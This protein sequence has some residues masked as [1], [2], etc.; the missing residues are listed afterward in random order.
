MSNIYDNSKDKTI[1]EIVK[2]RVRNVNN[3]EVKI[4]VGYFFLSGYNLVKEDFPEKVVSEDRAGK[5]PFLKIVMGNETSGKT[6]SEIAKGYSLRKEI[7]GRLASDLEVMPVG[8]DQVKAIRDL[9]ELI[10]K[11]V[12][13]IKLFEQARLHAKLYLNIDN[14]E[15]KHDPIGKAIVGSSNFTY[16]GMTQNRELNVNITDKGD[17][18]ELNVW[19]DTLWDEADDFNE[20]L[21]KIIGAS[22]IG[23]KIKETES[24]RDD[25]I[26][27]HKIL[28][29]YFEDQLKDEKLSAKY[30]PDEFMSLEYQDHAVLDALSIME[31]HGG[32]FI[33][34]VVGLGKTYISALLAQK[35]SGRILIICPPTL[36]DNWNEAF[37]LFKIGSFE[38]ESLGKLDRILEERRQY[39]YVIIDESHRFRNEGTNAYEMLHDICT[40]KKVI[41]V[42]ATPFNN[43]PDD[44]KNQILLFQRGTPTFPE[45]L[46]IEKFFSSIKRKIKNAR[47]VSPEEYRQVVKETSEEI[48]TKVLK[49]I[50]IRRTRKEIA[51]FYEKDLQNQGLKFPRVKQPEKIIYNFDDKT[52]TIFEYTISLLKTFNYYRYTPL[53][54]LKKGL[55]EFEKQQQRNI[56]GFMKA[57]LVKRLESSFY[58]F[59]KSLERFISSY[60][61]FIKMFNEGTVYISQDI[62]I[63]SYLEN[64]DLAG[65]EKLRAEGEDIRTFPASD[66]EDDYII[67]LG[68]DLAKIKEIYALWPENVKDPKLEQFLYELSNNQQLKRGKVIVFTE[69]KETGDYLYRKLCGQYG[70][71]VI[72]YWSN[73]AKYAGKEHNHT[74]SRDKIKKNF[75]PMAKEQEDD[76]KI[77]ITTDVLSEGINLHRSNCLINYDL[78]W[79]P[80]RLMQ[81]TGRINRVG[82]EHDFINIYNFF[83]TDDTEKELGLEECVKRKLQNFHDILGE[84]SKFLTDEEEITTHNLFGDN[85]YDTLN[86]EELY[87][88]EADFEN[89]EFEYF[90]IIKT[91]KDNHPGHYEKVK[92]YQ[93][94][95]MFCDAEK[96]KA[97][98][99]LAFFKTPNITR[100]FLAGRELDIL[101]AFM[102]LDKSMPG[103]EKGPDIKEK[104]ADSQRSFYNSISHL[105]RSRSTHTGKKAHRELLGR[106]KSIQPGS[107]VLSQEER[108]LLDKTIKLLS[109][110]GGLTEKLVKRV[111]K[112][113]AAT[114]EAG[115]IIAALKENIN[116]GYFED[117][118]DSGSKESELIEKEYFCYFSEKGN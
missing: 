21:L 35:L 70:D 9:K 17:V 96:A 72:Y 113:I 111:I 89:P 66:F 110:A 75:D 62:K 6:K 99:L 3:H 44:L 48:R 78:P 98:G 28:Y 93:V 55:S 90:K 49:P 92:A 84:D 74:I 47:E 52:S 12:I 91:I 116:A 22:P 101:A 112:K 24:T 68:Q 77:L 27:F 46:D 107:I 5:E 8:D 25:K 2:D 109:T 20:Q 11:N 10:G 29:E 73:G 26:F 7:C 71:S 86:N 105:G 95:R 65:L 60:E 114:N 76:L 45:I 13:E 58:A 63:N 40:N 102:L 43:S 88:D 37:T 106:L 41:L 38:V 30:L 32:V 39:D 64:D 87:N 33:S 97:R 118:R 23:K 83:P 42:S 79:N 115:E 108:D 34:D 1:A 15:S 117:T 59:R 18:E 50:M 19:F 103:K 67:K 104:V 54:Y 31:K 94:T 16:A 82:T 57:L 85:L 36:K 53:L 69:S 14:P 81:R 80:T 56:K 61:N 51:E 4:A 100:F